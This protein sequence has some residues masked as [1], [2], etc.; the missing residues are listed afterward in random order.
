MEPWEK[1]NIRREEAKE[2]S[3]VHTNLS[4]FITN[5]F[6]KDERIGLRNGRL[7]CLLLRSYRRLLLW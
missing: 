7:L 5:T 4:F 6:F 1:S 2:E 3:A